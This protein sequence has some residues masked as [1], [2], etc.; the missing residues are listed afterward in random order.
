MSGI[1]AADQLGGDRPENTT[2]PSAG[3]SRLSAKVFD[4]RDRRAIGCVIEQPDGQLAAHGRNGKIGEFPTHGEAERAVVD[5]H[6]AASRKA[7]RP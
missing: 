7:R 1:R 5:A 6:R 3:K 4:D 2:N